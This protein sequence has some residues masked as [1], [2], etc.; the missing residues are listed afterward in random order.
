MNKTVDSKTVFKFF[1]AQFLVR[2][3]RQKT[4]TFLAHNSKLMSVELKTSTFSAES[5]SVYIDNALL[6]PITKCQLFTMVKKTDFIGSLDRNP[7]KFQ[8]YAISDFSLF[9]KG[10]HF[11][12]E[13]QL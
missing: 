13:G 9:V 3:V 4:A 5:K 2:S 6:G 10:K 1:N 12:N 8:H 7:Y 11:R